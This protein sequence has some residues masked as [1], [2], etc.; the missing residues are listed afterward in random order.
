[1][2]EI[3]LLDEVFHI[4]SPQEVLAV[5]LQVHHPVFCL[6]LSAVFHHPHLHKQLLGGQWSCRQVQIQVMRLV[7]SQHLQEEEKKEMFLAKRKRKKKEGKEKKK[8]KKR[9]GKKR[10]RKGKRKKSGP[11]NTHDR[12]PTQPCSYCP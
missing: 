2:K 7:I 1:M 9:K 12:T 4:S 11:L 8:E 3:P 5:L 6:Q 10:K